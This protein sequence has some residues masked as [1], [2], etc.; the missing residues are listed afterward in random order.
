MTALGVRLNYAPHTWIY[1]VA[2]VAATAVI[3]GHVRSGGMG[4]RMAVS[5]DHSGMGHMAGMGHTHPMI[6]PHPTVMPMGVGA[7]WVWWVV[8]MMAMMLPVAAPSAAR[9]AFDSLW[10]RRHLAMLEY[11]VGYLAVWS[12]FGI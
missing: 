10:H 8:M 5:A 2:G 1:L 6:D 9:L 12:V 7:M 3:T 4:D 11:L